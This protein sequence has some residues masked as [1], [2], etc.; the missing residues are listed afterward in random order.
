MN[1]LSTVKQADWVAAGASAS[2]PQASPNSSKKPPDAFSGRTLTISA[3]ALVQIWTKRF[4][5]LFS[6]VFHLEETSRQYEPQN[7][8]SSR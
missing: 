4:Q 6:Y 1:D 5:S 2:G 7:Q 8:V 3:H